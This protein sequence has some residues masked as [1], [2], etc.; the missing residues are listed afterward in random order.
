MTACGSSGG[1]TSPT[2][3][4]SAVASATASASATTSASTSPSASAAD[5]KEI[6]VT[7]VGSKVTPAPDKVKVDKG[8]KVKLTVTRDTDGEIHVH[9]YDLEEQA[10]ANVPVTFE[11]TADEVG[12][13]E[14]E[15]HD[16]NRLLL[17][18]QVS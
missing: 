6:A 16:P 12:V 18:L 15:A 10:K 14:V 4:E 7:M 8:E 17:Q 3:A 2:V 11:F 9:G 13:F 1:D 5:V